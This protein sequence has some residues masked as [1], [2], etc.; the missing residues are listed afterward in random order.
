MI[1]LQQENSDFI[2][3]RDDDGRQVVSQTQQLVLCESWFESVMIRVI[4]A[5]LSLAAALFVWHAFRVFS[6]PHGC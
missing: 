6:T 1:M 2:F 5:V 3:D 4:V